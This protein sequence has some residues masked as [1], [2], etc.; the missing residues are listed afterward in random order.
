MKKI[1]NYKI[2]CPCL[3]K[4]QG[5]YEL[6]ITMSK[7]T[8]KKIEGSHGLP[9]DSSKLQAMTALI[10]SFCRGSRGISKAQSA[11][12]KAKTRFTLCA[13]RH[14]PCAFPLAAGGKKN[15][16]MIREIMQRSS[17]II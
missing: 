12:R 5:P 4:R 9:K 17:N 11:R 7:I 10:K 13:K 16:K 14:A 1:T 8:N 15:A 3:K 6:Q 2:Q